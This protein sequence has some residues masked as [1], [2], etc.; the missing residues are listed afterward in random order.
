MDEIARAASEIVGK[1]NAVGVLAFSAAEAADDLAN[2][3]VKDA[4]SAVVS[5]LGGVAAGTAAAEAAADTGALVSVAFGF[6]AA[7]AGTIV[8][9]MAVI[10]STLD[11][12]E[13]GL[14][15]SRN[16]TR[17]FNLSAFQAPVGS[18]INPRAG[19]NERNLTV[20][21]PRLSCVSHLYLYKFI[22][23]PIFHDEVLPYFGFRRFNPGPWCDAKG[24]MTLLIIN[25]TLLFIMVIPL[26]ILRKN[27]V[28]RLYC[29]CQLTKYLSF[30]LSIFFYGG[31][32]ADM[33]IAPA[34]FLDFLSIIDDRCIR[35]SVRS[36]LLAGPHSA[37]RPGVKSHMGI[38]GS[39]GAERGR[40]SCDRRHEV[41]Q[42]SSSTVE[43]RP[44]AP[45]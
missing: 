4:A 8:A 14:N 41:R 22:Y 18:L 16:F 15:A 45:I 13:D 26:I 24:F 25:Y 33:T 29:F 12:G 35:S 19:R 40:E 32:C 11:D 37:S 30:A 21:D 27:W 42:T 6:G 7:A 34:I 38:R 31:K 20:V 36:G 23:F 9:P 3:K 5:G 43:C 39:G 17:S 2:G 1:P 28:L 10:P 44:T